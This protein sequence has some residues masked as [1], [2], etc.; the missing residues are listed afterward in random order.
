MIDWGAIAALVPGRS[1]LQC[2]SRWHAFLEHS[3][4]RVT[5][6]TGAWTVDEDSKLE[7]AVQRHGSRNWGASSR[8][9]EILKHSIVCT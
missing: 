7:D 4:D 1:R 9:H 3:I 5:E 6:R 8:W 2:S